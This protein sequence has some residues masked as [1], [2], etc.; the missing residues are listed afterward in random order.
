MSDKTDRKQQRVR[1][2]A[3]ANMLRK[4][5]MGTVLVL[6]IGL[7]VFIAINASS[8]PPPEELLYENKPRIGKA[9][10]PVKLAEFGDY[11]CSHCK[12]FTEQIFPLIKKDFIDTGIVNFHF[13]GVHLSGLGYDSLVAA[14][15]AESVYR[16]NPDA[17]WDYYKAVY[18]AQ[19]D[20]G[21]PWATKEK[22]LGI[23]R[24]SNLKIDYDRLAKDIEEET[25]KDVVLDNTKLFNKM[26]ATGTPTL[27][28]NGEIID[29]S[30]Y[31]ELKK[32]IND[33][34]AKVK[35]DAE[36]KAKTEAEA[37]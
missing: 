18:A 5:V 37:K 1:A 6:V 14:G 2:R 15:A 10:A 16:Q 8:E 24:N 21:T 4:L 31:D 25:Y 35:A 34:A 29:Y 13:I 11:K 28:L 17:F 22:L 30:S 20:A 12:D 33:A 3:R 36:A 19:E 26:R 9:D 32:L 23:A 27:V 7:G